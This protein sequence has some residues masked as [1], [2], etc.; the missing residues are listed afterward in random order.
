MCLVPI[1][2][3]F[4]TAIEDERC[5]IRCGTEGPA[6]VAAA[7][8]CRT[9]QPV[10]RG[11]PLLTAYLSD[12]SRRTSATFLLEYGF[13]PP[14]FSR[15]LH[16]DLVAVPLPRWRRKSAPAFQKQLMHTC[17]PGP[18]TV[19][20]PANDT[21]AIPLLAVFRILQL[22]SAPSFADPPPADCPVVLFA[23]PTPTD[24][25]A[26]AEL[27]R[28]VTVVLAGYPSPRQVPDA[29]GEHPSSIASSVERLLDIETAALRRILQVCG[30][31]YHSQKYQLDLHRDM[32]GGPPF[33][34]NQ[35]RC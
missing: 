31:W 30:L 8:V 35:N 9:T 32:L 22:S 17:F 27:V 6:G 16:L 23:P 25:A 4:N 15:Q 29:L 13:V 5:N 24:T 18:S 19:A 12:A 2:D 20:V 26:I 28:H 11:S 10:A 7:F 21:A 14:E 33:Y 34:R 3:L 1:A